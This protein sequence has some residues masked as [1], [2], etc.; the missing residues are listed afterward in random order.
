MGKKGKGDDVSSYFTPTK[1]VIQ[2]MQTNAIRSGAIIS[3]AASKGSDKWDW[4]A[5]KLND[6]RWYV[7]FYY[8]I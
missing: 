4:N 1:A 5:G 2:R 7:C 6:S 8:Y 3:S